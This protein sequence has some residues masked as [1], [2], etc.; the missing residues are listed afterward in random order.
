MLGRGI[1][2]GNLYFSSGRIRDESKA[3]IIKVSLLATSFATNALSVYLRISRP[4]LPV[5]LR[6]MAGR[7]ARQGDASNA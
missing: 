1:C 6:N 5:I 4:G 2:R 7:T 3:R